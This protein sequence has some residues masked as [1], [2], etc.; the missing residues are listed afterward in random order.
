MSRLRNASIV[1]AEHKAD[2]FEHS[3]AMLTYDR[4]IARNGAANHSR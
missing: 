1:C 4:P 3:T 2:F